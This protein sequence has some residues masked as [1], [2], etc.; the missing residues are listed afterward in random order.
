MIVVGR[1]AERCECAVDVGRDH[2]DQT[3]PRSPVDCRV[4]IDG[5]CTRPLGSGHPLSIDGDNGGGGTSVTGS[6]CSQPRPSSRATF[7]DR[8]MSA[9]SGMFSSCRC[10]SR[11]KRAEGVVPCSDGVDEAMGMGGASRASKCV[12]RCVAADER[13]DRDRLDARPDRD[14]FDDRRDWL[15]D[16]WP[17]RASGEPGVVSGVFRPPNEAR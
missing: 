1:W 3:L 2:R 9:L 5:R 10:T 15:D 8:A 7:C 16:D 4:P 14:A 12:E 11:R 13:L 6:C 17:D